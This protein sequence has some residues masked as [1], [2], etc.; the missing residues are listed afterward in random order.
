MA[1]IRVAETDEEN[2]R[3]IAQHAVMQMTR[4]P[5]TLDDCELLPL[6][7]EPE[8]YIRLSPL[9]RELVVRLDGVWDVIRRM[10]KQA[11][12]LGFYLD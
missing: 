12:E 11:I 8:T 9:E 2:L 7:K 5:L 10:D 1:E 4:D 3:A 6:L